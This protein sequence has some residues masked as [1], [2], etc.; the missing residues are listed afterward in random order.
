LVS[1]GERRERLE[2]ERQALYR[3]QAEVEEQ[4]AVRTA[5]LRGQLLP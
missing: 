1:W 2:A 3:R 5:A 4:A